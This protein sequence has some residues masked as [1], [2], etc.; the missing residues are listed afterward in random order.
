MKKKKF[1]RFGYQNRFGPKN[2]LMMLRA[3]P[4]GQG[5]NDCKITL[6]HALPVET[7]S[8]LSDTTVLL[9]FTG[10]SPP[11]LPKSRDHRAN[12]AVPVR[13]VAHRTSP[14]GRCRKMNRPVAAQLK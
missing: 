13:W 14:V 1:H 4:S 2:R 12:T 8:F 11:T 3:E 10:T 6:Q 7:N 9:V 5:G